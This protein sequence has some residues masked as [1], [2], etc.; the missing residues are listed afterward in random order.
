[1]TRVPITLSEAKT[2][3]A[4]TNQEQMQA[5]EREGYFYHEVEN[6]YAGIEQRWLVVWYESRRE[7]ELTQ[8]QK[9]IGREADK[10]ATA[11]KK[12]KRQ[13]FNCEEDAQKSLDDFTKQWSFHRVTG[14]VYDVT[15]FT[16]RE[17]IARR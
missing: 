5:G 7:Q 10:L 4:E 17:R 3:M 12:L 15:R 13:A 9:R 2:L 11:V 14:E 16:Q 8:L 6:H 1:M